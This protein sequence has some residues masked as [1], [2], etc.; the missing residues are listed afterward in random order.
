MKA[1]NLLG[2]VVGIVVA[3][4]LLYIIGRS[5]IQVVHQNTVAVVTRWGKHYAVWTAGLHF[6]VPFADRIRRVFSS[7]RQTLE[8]RVQGDSSGKLPVDVALEVEVRSTLDPEVVKALAYETDN[9]FR[10]LTAVAMA[11]ARELLVGIS[12]EEA[13]SDSDLHEKFCQALN[14]VADTCGYK[15]LSVRVVSIRPERSVHEAVL[16]GERAR[17]TRKDEAAQAE[18]DA[19]VQV[20]QARAAAEVAGIEADAER[21]SMS[22]KA[23]QLAGLVDA[24][25]GWGLSGAQIAG[26]I[27]ASLHLQ[28][29]EAANGSN[30]RVFLDSPVMDDPH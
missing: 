6:K 15:I 20:G 22:A 19:A 13:V 11:A 1:M 5:C 8:L 3:V 21:D 2:L 14:D 30:A 23:T 17:V 16:A 29:V 24:L 12:F 18:H 25:Q 28:A 27:N 7:Q 10:H 26:I 9:P 4:V